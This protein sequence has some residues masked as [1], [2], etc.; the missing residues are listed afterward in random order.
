MLSRRTFLHQT[1][2]AA[3]VGAMSLAAACA[4]TLPTAPAPPAKP[5]A[6][7]LPTYAAFNGPPADQPGSLQSVQP[8]F[9]SYPKSP[10]K[11]VTAPAGKG[12]DKIRSEFQ[13]SLAASK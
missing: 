7:K 2:V 10:V 8:V 11:S 12:G 1:G 6:L 9:V 3:T 4:P 13:D 5:A